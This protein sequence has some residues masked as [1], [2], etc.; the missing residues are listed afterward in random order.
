MDVAEVLL[1]GVGVRYEFVTEA[2]DRLRIVARRDGS[3]DVLGGGGDPD[4]AATLF[5]LTAQEADTVAEL[6]GAPRIAERLADLTREIPGLE[7]GQVTVGDRSPYAGRTLGDTRA[8][9]RTGA[10]IVAIVRGRDVV[11]APA[12]NQPL[13]AGDVLVVIG[14]SD[15]V[16]AVADLVRG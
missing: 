7:A 10:S 6:L 11:A 4:A 9:T 12:P 8:R 16:A 14:T 2:G 5:T 1:P 15:G 13:Y 3:V